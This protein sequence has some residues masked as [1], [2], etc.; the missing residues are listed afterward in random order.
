MSVCHQDFAGSATALVAGNCEIDWR[1]GASRAYY[2]AFHAALVLEDHLPDNSHLAMGDH[3]R[4]SE[5]YKLEGSKAAKGV[6]YALQAMKRLRH[7]ADYDLVTSFP[8]IHAERQ[9]LDYTSLCDRLRAL[10]A[11]LT[12]TGQV[13]ATP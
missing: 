13:K 1:N 2:G 6:A 9:L 3:E 4:L 7:L 8:K 10:E 5:R 11:Q 12:S